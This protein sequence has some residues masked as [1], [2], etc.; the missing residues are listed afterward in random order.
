MECKM[1]SFDQHDQLPTQEKNS[2]VKWSETT[3]V[4]HVHAFISAV[5]LSSMV[6]SLQLN[7]P[8][9]KT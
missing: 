5:N 7:R 6:Y 9:A 4:D 1:E 2:E 8:F 3:Y